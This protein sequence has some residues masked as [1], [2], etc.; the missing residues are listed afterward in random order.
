MNPIARRSLSTLI[1]PKVVSSQNIGSAPNAKRIGN[2]V[3]FYKSLPQGPAPAI[4]PTGLISKY[5]A[6]YF[7]G[8]NASGKPLW[9]LAVSI[10]V[11]GYSLEYYFH[12]RH[13]KNGE[14]H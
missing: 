14:H 12:L 2:V 1:P 7:D 8:D 9:H 13:S 11:M 3:Q 5:K 10:L 4:K 6:K